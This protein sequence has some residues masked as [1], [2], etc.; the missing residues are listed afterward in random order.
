[1]DY[2]R[3]KKQITKIEYPIIGYDITKYI[4]MIIININFK[5][6]F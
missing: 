6:Y 5:N 1:M 3:N 4:E 2:V